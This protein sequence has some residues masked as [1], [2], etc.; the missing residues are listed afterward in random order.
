MPLK[1]ISL[2]RVLVPARPVPMRRANSM[3]QVMQIVVERDWTMVMAR[4]VWL[5]WYLSGHWT[6]ERIQFR[7]LTTSLKG[8]TWKT[9]TQRNY[10]G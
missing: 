9:P 10:F 5:S 7:R 4:E 1:E 8:R 3:T 2:A 6:A